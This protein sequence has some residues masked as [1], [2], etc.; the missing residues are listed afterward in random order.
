M[1]RAEGLKEIKGRRGVEGVAPTRFL[2]LTHKLHVQ[3]LS[4]TP[5]S[6]F[7]LY[8]MWPTSG[9]FYIK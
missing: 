3:A 2:F 4:H 9:K 7:R 6:Q 5:D 8:P 1:K